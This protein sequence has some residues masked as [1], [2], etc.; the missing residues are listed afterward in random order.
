M[1]SHSAVTT[2][3]HFLALVAIRL[4][5]MVAVCLIALAAPSQLHR[6]QVACST[7][8]VGAVQSPVPGG[9]VD[10]VIQDMLRHD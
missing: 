6:P 4:A 3:E 8:A 2:S 7:V 5:A 1:A 9:K 10:E